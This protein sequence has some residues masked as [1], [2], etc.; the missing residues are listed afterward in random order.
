MNLRSSL[1]AY[2]SKLGVATISVVPNDV[3][4]VS[5][6]VRVRKIVDDFIQLL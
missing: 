5:V 2:S 4:D 6:L 3:L 1:L